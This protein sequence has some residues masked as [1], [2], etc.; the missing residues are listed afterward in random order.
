[1]PDEQ[2]QQSS[3]LSW[4]MMLALLFLAMLAATGIAYWIL[5]PFF[6]RH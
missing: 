2:S 3:G 6:H 5:Y 4:G 1:M